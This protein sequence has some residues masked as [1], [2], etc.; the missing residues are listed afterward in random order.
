[1]TPIIFMRLHVHGDTEKN[2]LKALSAVY[3]EGLDKYGFF[4]VQLPDGDPR[5]EL[6]ER[7]MGRLAI[8]MQHKH[9]TSQQM[10][11]IRDRNYSKYRYHRY[12]D[13]DFANAEYFWIPDM[14]GGEWD[15]QSD[16]DR[17]PDGML[18]MMAEYLKPRARLMS[19]GYDLFV[20]SVQGRKEMEEEGF[21]GLG[22]HPTKQCKDKLVKGEYTSVPHEPAPERVVWELRPTIELP[23]MHAEAA[24]TFDG[25]PVPP[26]YQGPVAFKNEGFDDIQLVYAR[27]AISRVA[28][29]DIAH[30]RE[31]RVGDGYKD[32]AF[33]IIVSQRFYKY[34]KAKRVQGKFIPV[35]IVEGE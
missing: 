31:W 9:F 1:M 24:R 10:L 13:S 28:P 2:D 8:P 14:D 12:D 33:P 19:N 11:P 4:I 7:E 29:F 18:L 32:P 25:N 5:I 16:G 23:P 20:V 30:A 35:K 26:G 3:P 17:G 34:C 27:S 15:A 6:V 22:F 21:V